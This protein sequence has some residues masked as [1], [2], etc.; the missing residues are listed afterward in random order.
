MAKLLVSMKS[1]DNTFVTAD[2]RRYLEDRFDVTYGEEDRL[3]SPEE[4]SEKIRDFDAVLTGW[5]HPKITAD[6]LGD[7]R[8]SVLAHTGGTVANVADVSLYDRG[9]RV[10]SGNE[11]YAESVAEGTVGYM[12][13]GLR[14]IPHYI[15]K[16][17]AGGWRE[18]SFYNEGLLDQTVGIIGC[19]AVARHLMRML[20]CFRVKIKVFDTYEI[21]RDFLRAMGAEQVSMEEVFSTC[22]IVSVHCAMTEATR[23]IIGR[24]QFGMLQ[25]GA[26]FLNTA[27]GAVI[28]EEEMIE[29]LR[30]NRFSAV[31]DVYCQEPLAADSPLRSLPNV[32]CIPHMGGPTMDRR[33][34]VTERLADNIEKILRGEAAELEISLE[35]ALRMT[36]GG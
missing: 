33:P 12:L 25:N 14:R 7:S 28:R 36:V 11:L 3:Y 19:G 1:R 18:P 6:M 23:G 22:R 10:L 34:I 9:I 8:L 32:Y 21:D 5:G 13:T 30:E 4:F 31:L 35:T 27:R 29:A 17:R 24:A 26:L 16:V 2:V 20:Q 15:N